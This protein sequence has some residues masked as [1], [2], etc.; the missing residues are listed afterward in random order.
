MHEGPDSENAVPRPVQAQPRCL[1]KEVRAVLLVDMVDSVRLIAAD[2][3][4]TVARWLNLVG[5]VTTKVLPNL[6]GRL[7]K[8]LGD[9]MLLEFP[10]ARSAAAAA[11]EIQASSRKKNEAVAAGKEILLRMGIE[12]GVVIVGDND[13][14]GH[15]VNVAARL[16]TTLAR[17]GEIIIS[18]HARDQL[19]PMLDADVE[20]LGDCYLKNVESPVRAYRIGPPGLEAMPVLYGIRPALL[21][22]IA[23]VPFAARTQTPEHQV[24]GEV[25]ADELIGALSRSHSIDVISRLSTTA[26]RVR[27]ASVAEIGRHLSVN[28][29]LSGVYHTDTRS[30]V[31][32]LEL[33]EVRSER[34]IWSERLPAQLATLLSSELELINRIVADVYKAIVSQELKRARSARLPTLESYTLLLG[35]I[36]LMHRMSLRDFLRARDMLL[37]LIDRGSRQ[38]IPQAWLAQWYVLRIQQGWTDDIGRDTAEAVRCANRALDEDPDSS[39]A[40]AIDGLVHTHMTKRHDVAQERYNLAV[41]SNPNDALAWLLKGTQ[42]A[43][44]GDGVQ[45]VS[46]TQRALRLSPLDPHSYYYNS[47]SAT[48]HITAGNNQLALQ[49]AEVSL[50]ANRSHTSTLRVKAV[51][52]WRLGLEQEAR[53]TAAELLRLEPNL[54]VSGWLKRS[55][56]APYPNGQAFAKTL[57]SIGIPE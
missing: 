51:A 42:H 49:H 26:F 30:I 9:G 4:G 54:T 48:A 5:E 17:P 36:S 41:E 8:S 7:V 46:D 38:S 34:V 40:L 14:Y 32:D 13:V 15:S 37:A 43:L 18:A 56:S 29:V 12:V 52:Q 10:D 16:M 33:S 55:P 24:L 22:S 45:A 11:F 47:L 35:A 19:V 3:A 6:S 1:N 27:P 25:L 20:D 50:R 31:V 23:V 57:V 53:L 28:Y 44:T 39:L 2:E 21:P